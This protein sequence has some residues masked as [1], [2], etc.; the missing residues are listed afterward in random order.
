M[1][2]IISIALIMSMLIY[3]A[4]ST[5]P[6]ID[7]EEVTK[8]KEKNDLY[9]TV[10]EKDRYYLTAGNYYIVGDTLYGIAKSTPVKSDSKSLKVKLCMDDI[11]RF[12]MRKSSPLLT[13]I[14][15]VGITAG[16]VLFVLGSFVYAVSHSPD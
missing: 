1:K 4:C 10:Q 6:Y 11:T 8:M 9:V 3:Q 12:E 2:Y 16:V 15:V 5:W 7:K 13:V 14:L